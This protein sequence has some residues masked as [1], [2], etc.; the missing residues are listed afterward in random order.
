[1]KALGAA[2]PEQAR[3]RKG[4][5]SALPK[6][7]DGAVV[8][9]NIANVAP[10]HRRLPEKAGSPPGLARLAEGVDEL[11]HTSVARLTA[12][13]S[14][15]ALFGAYSDWVTHQ[16][17]SP[18]R[19]MLLAGQ[20]AQSAAA[21]SAYAWRSLLGQADGKCIEPRPADRRF[22]DAS[23]NTWPFNLIHQAFLLQEQWWQNA[24][25]GVEGVTRQ[26]ED[27]VSFVARQILDTVA[28]SNF[29]PTNPEVLDKTIATG[30]TNL[31]AGY[32]NLIED[33][34]RALSGRRPVGAERFQVGENIAATRG[35]VV[36]RN[37]LIELIQYESTTATVCPEPLLIV[38]A[39]IMKYYILDL[40]PREL[41]RP[42]PRR[43]RLHGV[44]HFLEE[45]G[46]R[47][48]RSRPRRLSRAWHRG[49]ARGNRSD[50]PRPARSRARLLPWRHDA[51]HCRRGD[52]P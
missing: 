17:F 1:M 13:L 25:T 46:P 4:R 15:T 39:W 26:H 10:A 27:V 16:A 22:V 35:K 33:R 49:G 51:D 37:R 43:A 38:P 45:P 23:W 41:A 20:A 24:T 2:T 28:P 11:V 12:G 32:A 42:L 8:A 31:V 14:P 7:A 50:R 29:I 18:G 47:R 21:L 3:D 6:V 5:G 34:Q 36:Y 9:G 19:Q 52:G 48:P 30:G 44:H 40:S